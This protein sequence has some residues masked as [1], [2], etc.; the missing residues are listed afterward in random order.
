[1][2]WPC[3]ECGTKW[4]EAVPRCPACD[5]R[6]IKTLTA[7][8][9]QLEQALTTEE[10]PNDE[11]AVRP[12]ASREGLAPGDA[13]TGAAD[14]EAL[15]VPTADEVAASS[16]SAGAGQMIPGPDPGACPRCG[17]WRKAGIDHN[18]ELGQVPTAIEKARGALKRYG[19]HDASCAR[20]QHDWRVRFGKSPRAL[21]PVCLCGYEQALAALAALDAQETT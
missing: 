20:Y 16:V 15:A 11:Y 13:A 21:A 9:H 18:C 4:P 5:V 6:E 1:M 14:L 19:S 12:E 7:R 17:V 8:V 2:T 10:K 3:G